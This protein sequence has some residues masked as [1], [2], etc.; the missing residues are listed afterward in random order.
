LRFIRFITCALV[1]AL[2]SLLP[3][4]SQSLPKVRI[5]VLPT[6]V[7]DAAVNAAQLGYFKDAGIDAEIVALTNGG[8][9]ASAIVSGAA[10]IAFSN[11]LSVI[12]A[13]AKGLPVTVVVGADLH[14]ATS[15]DQGILAA[16]TASS[17]RTG[18]DFSGKTV[19]VPTLGSTQYYAARKW[20]DANGGDST[21]VHF[22]ELANPTIAD[23]IVAGRVD[24]GTIDI[25]NLHAHRTSL[26][27][28]ASAFDSIAPRFLAG[29]WFSTT[30]WVAKNP[31]LA[32][33]F[34]AAYTRY[35]T[36][37][38]SHPADEIA[39]YAKY[40]GLPAGDLQAVQRPTFEPVTNMDLLQPLIDVAVKYGAIAKTFRAVEL[41][42]P[43][44]APARN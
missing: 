15:P 37:A 36:W 3:A 28:V 8:A 22:I 7:A 24:A 38:N 29:I 42:S 11:A 6:E 18:A 44:L 39:F 10:D 30:D 14:R 21:S 13:H 4:G 1:V 26:R 17:L 40:S 35:S 25:L 43:A 34:V 2:A 9:S 31:D 41:Q 20:I 19:A 23:A 33:R 12:V 32:R 5:I 27:Q 16:P